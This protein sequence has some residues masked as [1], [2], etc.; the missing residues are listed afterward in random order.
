MFSKKLMEYT[1]PETSH[2]VPGSKNSLAQN[3]FGTQFKTTYL[4]L[5]AHLARD[6]VSQELTAAGKN[7]GTKTNPGIWVLLLERIY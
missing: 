7:P 3:C 4:Q 6:S 1:V 2:K 5:P